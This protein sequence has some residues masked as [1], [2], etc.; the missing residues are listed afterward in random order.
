ME[1]PTP[2]AESELQL[3]AYPTA[4][5]TQDPSHIC[6]LHHSSQQRQILNPLSEAKDRTHN[7]MVPSWIRFCCTI[8]GTPQPAF[9][10]DHYLRGSPILFSCLQFFMDIFSSFFYEG[11]AENRVP[12]KWKFAIII[13]VSCFC[14]QLPLCLIKNLSQLKYSSLVATVSII[15]VTIITMK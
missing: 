5:A 11:A 15:L 6:S 8:M 9:L 2:G 13:T 3:P 10:N 4:T 1:V 12:I 7:L 14:L